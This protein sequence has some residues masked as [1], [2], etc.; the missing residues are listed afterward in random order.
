MHLS[1]DALAEFRVLWEEDHLGEEIFDEEL[2]DIALRVLR[3]IDAVYRP[4]PVEKAG[5][6]EATHEPGGS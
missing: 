5:A 4:I 3:A 6:F 2:S 1:D